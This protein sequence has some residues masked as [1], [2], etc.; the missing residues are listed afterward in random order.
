MASV[1]AFFFVVIE[2]YELYFTGELVKVL[3]SLLYR[4][5]VIN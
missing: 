1:S 3:F 2:V 4:A 5:I